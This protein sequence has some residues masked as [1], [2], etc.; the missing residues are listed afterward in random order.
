MPKVPKHRV[1]AQRVVLVRAQRPRNKTISCIG[2]LRTHPTVPVHL[3]VGGAALN[4]L[5][6]QQARNHGMPVRGVYVSH[7]GYMLRQARINKGSIIMAVNGTATCVR[8]S[9]TPLSQQGARDCS[10]TGRCSGDE[11]LLTSMMIWS[12]VCLP[13]RD[14]SSHQDNAGTAPSDTPAAGTRDGYV[15][16]YDCVHIHVTYYMLRQARNGTP[17]CVR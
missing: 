2:Q 8:P 1:G 9:L 15:V 7:P 10:K 6:F 3:Q 17:T 12:M 16:R 13:P 4:E 14:T 11:S 5:S